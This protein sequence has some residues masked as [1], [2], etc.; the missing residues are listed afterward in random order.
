MGRS[1]VERKLAE[2]LEEL[3]KLK[4]AINSNHIGLFDLG[5]YN[6]LK[7]EIASLERELAEIDNK[8]GKPA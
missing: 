6:S 3:K 5:R 8:K 4:E 2:D 1:E 7:I